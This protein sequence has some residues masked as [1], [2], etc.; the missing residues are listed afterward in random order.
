MHKSSTLLSVVAS[1]GLVAC[2]SDSAVKTAGTSVAGNGTGGSATIGCPNPVPLAGVPSGWVRV[3]G[4]TLIDGNPG[5][6][7]L[8]TVQFQ[9]EMQTP[10]GNTASASTLTEVNYRNGDAGGSSQRLLCRDLQGLSRLGLTV[11]PWDAISTIDGSVEMR[12][13]IKFVILPSDHSAVAELTR[14]DAGGN[15]GTESANVEA[16][17]AKARAM[18]IVYDSQTYQISRTEFEVRMTA[19]VPQT[20][21]SGR[22]MTFNSAF[23]YQLRTF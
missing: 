12:R 10:E 17:K 4:K 22:T 11:G 7:L 23:R 3:A 8:K 1:L 13:N 19:T 16:E 15:F 18:G 9:T 6:W 5:Q 21:R 14:A 2:G 20:D